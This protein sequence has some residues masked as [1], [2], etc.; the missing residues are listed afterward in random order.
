MLQAIVSWSI[1]QRLAVVALAGLLIVLG[2]YAAARA[3]LDVF[4]EFAP[5]QV[6]VQTEA[7]GLSPVEVEQLVT[8][9][10]EQT[11]NGL[12]RLDTLRSQSIQGLSVVTLIFQDG[13][14]SYR[15]RQQIGERL[16]EL[17]GQLPAIVRA[18]RMTPLTPA[19]GRLL[20][21]GLTSA[22]R[23]P[24]EL[25]DL[26]Q[27]T[28]RPRL[29]SV[30]GVAQVTL[31]GGAVRQFQVQ[32]Q[33]AFL[34]AGPLTLSDVL[35]AVRQAS[36]ILG[37]GFIENP[38]QRLT[39]RVEAQATSAQELGDTLIVPAQGTPIRL[40]DVARIVEAPEPKIGDATIEGQPGVLL[41]VAKQVGADTLDVT[42]RVEAEMTKL[43]PVLQAQ[44]VTY[45]PALFRQANFIEHAVGNVTHSLVLGAMLVA[46]VL[47]VF[48][49]NVRTAFISLT[50]IPL[51]LLSAVLVLTVSGVSLNTLTLGGLAI[52]V[53]EVVDDAIIDVENIFRRLRENARLPEPRSRAA[54]VLAASLEVRSAVVYATLIVVLV[55]IPIFFLTGLQGR[56]FA[57]LGYAYVLAVLA[58]LAVALT[59]T[60]ALA[61]LLLP[62][63]EPIHGRSTSSSWWARLQGTIANGHADLEHVLFARYERLLRW[64]NGELSL[65]L[66]VVG[67][68]LGAAVLAAW[69]FGGAFLPEL[70]ENHYIV[71]MRGLPG[72]SLQQSLATGQSVTEALHALPEVRTV[73]QQAGRA[74]LG[75]DTWG[76]E[77]SELEVDLHTLNAA[78]LRQVERQLRALPDQFAGYFFEPMPF[79]TERIKETLSGSHASVAVKIYGDD[80]ESLDRAAQQIARALNAIPGR[81]GKPAAAGVLIE[82]QTG[83]PE[84]VIRVRREDAAR[85]GLRPAQILETVHTAYQGA[86]VGQVHDRNRIIDYVVVLDPKARA[87]VAGVANLWLSVPPG[88]TKNPP[89]ATRPPAGEGGESATRIP[90]NSAGRVQLAQVAD[91][92]LSNGRF[93]VSH[94]GGLRRQQVTCNV[95]PNLDVATFV[96][97]AEAQVAKLQLPPGTTY[98]FTGEH[99]ARIS[100]VRELAFWSLVVGAGI[101]LLLGMV[102]RSGRRLLLLL[103]NLPFAAVGGIAAVY[104]AGGILDVGALIGFVTLF[105]ITTRNAIMM[106][107]HWQH[108]HEE[109]GLPWGPELVF[110]GARE[111]LAPVLM[112]AL[113]TALG[114]LPIALGSG[115]AGR[116]IEGPMAQV[117]LGGLVT[118]T[119]LNLLVLPVLFRRWGYVAELHPLGEPGA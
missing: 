27:W 119:A 106:V 107:S 60:P 117:I 95:G 29:L 8:G 65:V 13:T 112:T 61:M 19:T 73:A 77:Y 111:R 55:F 17:A 56:L 98:V 86:V 72:T 68:L 66:A 3:Q 22:Q 25:R 114:L 5:P 40:K 80:L 103:G 88:E 26:A 34:A 36:G 104:L 76:V 31:F 82:P 47:F 99:E 93:L 14:D 35:D 110:R 96:R 64:L 102:F 33:P 9:P 78:Q 1:A 21:I 92:Y 75:E 20:T 37:A 90:A 58:S 91:V 49:G 84:L 59:V 70:R 97:G 69:Q 57:P 18:P 11:L 116:E 74:E 105:G 45:H 63:A 50:A 42:R 30:R 41:I 83:S 118:S 71:H 115:E 52:A 39:L 89:T 16:A 85:L 23:S 2:V 109:D 113:V 67:V 53:G 51:S 101:V 12:P 87:D 38:N 62:T 4:P 54:V 81:D 24:M 46:V 79:L 100:A 108:L 44:H 48:L 7:P 15:A 43:Q 28:I 10:I 6:V 32:V 94:E